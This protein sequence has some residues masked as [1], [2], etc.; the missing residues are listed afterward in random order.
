MVSVLKK[1]QWIYKQVLLPVLTYG[2]H[3]WGTHPN[4]KTKT[5]T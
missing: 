5:S 3:D 4:S 1:M 2:C